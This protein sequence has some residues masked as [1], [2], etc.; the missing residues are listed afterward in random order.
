MGNLYSAIEDVESGGNPLAESLKGAVGLMQIRQPALD[1]YNNAHNE[2]LTMD[3]ME[4]VSSNRKVGRW[5]ISKRIPQMLSKSRIP[6]TLDNVLWAYNAGISKIQQGIM[7]QETKEYIPKVKG[8]L[9]GGEQKLID[10][11]GM[12]A[13]AVRHG[14]FSYYHGKMGG[15]REV[16]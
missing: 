7:P 5:Y 9:K 2:G 4:D 8:R 13:D 12:T 6:V 10:K 14:P 16:R 11:E 3:D 15:E 1:D